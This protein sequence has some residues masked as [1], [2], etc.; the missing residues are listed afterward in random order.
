MAPHYNFSPADVDCDQFY[1][2]PIPKMQVLQKLGTFLHLKVGEVELVWPEEFDTNALPYLYNEIFLPRSVNPHAYESDG[3]AIRKGDWVIDGGACEGFF[4]LYAL[5]RGA[6]V[7]I[8]EP[9][10]RLCQALTML[11][12]PFIEQKRVLIIQGFLSDFTG[13]APLVFDAK[14]V[15]ESGTGESSLMVPCYTLDSLVEQ[16]VI[17][18]CDFLKLDVEGAEMAVLRGA[19]KVM[20]THRPRLSVAVYHELQNPEECAAIVR[21]ANPSY[22]LAFQGKFNWEGCAPRPYLLLGS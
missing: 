18:R 6:S 5:E 10:E 21:K 19:A 14:S 13:L 9:V 12:K 17:P 4:T 2:L 20:Q 7:V 8:V 1:R 22:G 3:V 15:C 16:N 11:L